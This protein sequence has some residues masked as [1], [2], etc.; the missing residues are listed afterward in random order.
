MTR[1]LLALALLAAA[2]RADDTKPDGDK[3]ASPPLPAPMGLTFVKNADGLRSPEGFEVEAVADLGPDARAVTF[4][5][6][7]TFYVL[8]GG[9]TASVVPF[10]GQPPVAGR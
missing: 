10:K 9:K 1:S 8:R 2:C 3:P 5:D 7:G 6:D 4:A